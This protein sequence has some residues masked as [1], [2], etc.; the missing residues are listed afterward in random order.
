M[1]RES[2]LAA[3]VWGGGERLSLGFRSAAQ[4]AKSASVALVVTRM[5]EGESDM[6]WWWQRLKGKKRRGVT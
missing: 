2:Q 4:A 5:F 3:G 1:R 6:G